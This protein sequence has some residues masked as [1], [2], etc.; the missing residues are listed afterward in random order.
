MVEFQEEAKV[1]VDREGV[2]A[3][4]LPAAARAVKAA[5]AAGMEEEATNRQAG[6][7]AVATGGVG[8]GWAEAWVVTMAAAVE[9]LAAVET[10]L[11]GVL[12]GEVRTVLV[13]ARGWWHPNRSWQSGSRWPGRLNP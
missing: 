13:V 1:A 10:A 11:V 12:V 4:V 7:A 3:V 9:E 2:M 6:W 5:A 8:M